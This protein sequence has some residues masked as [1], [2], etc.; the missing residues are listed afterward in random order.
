MLA[1]LQNS[2]FI[3]WKENI[4]FLDNAWTELYQS[5]INHGD[6]TYLQEFSFSG[7]R[8]YLPDDFY[9][10]YYV[11]YTNGTYE[12][13]IARKAKTSTGQ[14][15]YYDIV[16][17]EL[18]IYRDSVSNM[19]KIKVQYYPVKQAITYRPNNIIVDPTVVN[20][21]LSRYRLSDVVPIS[22]VDVAGNYWLYIFSY[23]VSAG[24]ISYLT[25]Y[26]YIIFDAAK[27]IIKTTIDG[28]ASA[29]S[30]PN[31]IYLTGNEPKVGK[32]S[33]SNNAMFKLRINNVAYNTV[34][35]NS[36]FTIYKGTQTTS[37]YKTYSCSAALV[38][39]FSSLYRDSWITM[40]G[41]DLFAFKSDSPNGLYRL[42]LISGDFTEIDSSAIRGNVVSFNDNV[43][44]NS[45]NGIS[46]DGE[47]ILD[48][49]EYSDFNIVTE[50]NMNTG[51]G[52]L[53][54]SV[55]IHG[56]FEDTELDFPNNFFYNFLAYKLAIYYK[57]KQ[58]AD[59]S[60]LM[61]ML[62]EAEKTFYDTLPR[63]ENNFVRIAN[64]YAY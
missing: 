13:P 34:V 10:L 32:I 12:K 49:T 14:G 5:L 23:S 60:G 35:R 15:P 50:N 30:L 54:D 57:I 48:S 43:Y 19:N 4:M 6:K 44:Y 22:C 56:I 46:K 37:P 25:K 3:S 58:N 38:D 27:G 64:A 42:N 39:K 11:C 63:D 62:S 24:S 16:G 33:T 36:M 31:V 26:G 47:I 45:A 1:D 41:D 21:A 28:L 9:Q 55:T 59:P 51:Y 53:T 17:N 29:D 40:V 7:E 18:I 61:V 8:T 20:G 2:D 52:I